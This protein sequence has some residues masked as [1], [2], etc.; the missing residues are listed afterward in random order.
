MFFSIF[1]SLIVATTL[2][3]DT[4]HAKKKK[5]QKPSRKF[6]AVNVLTS[7]GLEPSLDGFCNDP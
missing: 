4:T 5:E 1:V 6:L 3:A 2:L 7:V